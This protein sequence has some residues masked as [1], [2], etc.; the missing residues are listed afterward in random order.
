M[1]G[2][3]ECVPAPPVPIIC[4]LAIPAV[5]FQS[6]WPLPLRPLSLFYQASA[7]GIQ[8]PTRVWT[9]VS[10]FKTNPRDLTASLQ[11]CAFFFDTR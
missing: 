4:H 10:F 6:W 2:L 1:F 3:P 5:P 9:L 11:S 7:I 8:D